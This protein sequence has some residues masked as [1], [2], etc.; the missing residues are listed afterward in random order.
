MQTDWPL[1]SALH[2][3][4]KG[5]GTQASSQQHRMWALDEGVGHFV[6][7]P[8]THAYSIN[9]FL[10]SISDTVQ[11]TVKLDGGLKSYFLTG[12]VY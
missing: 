7:P 2:R 11:M 10:S 1:S 12:S 9:S 8:N 6:L 5:E 3:G 4:E